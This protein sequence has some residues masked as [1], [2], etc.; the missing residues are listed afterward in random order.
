M[1][2]HTLTNQTDQFALRSNH[3]YCMAIRFGRHGFELVWFNVY[4]VLPGHFQSKIRFVFT[5]PC[6]RNDSPE[7]GTQKC[8]RQQ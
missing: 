1:N 5:T 7:S 2:K 6:P 8:S 3:M 4:S